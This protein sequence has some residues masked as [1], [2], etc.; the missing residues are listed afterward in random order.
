LR[1]EE[2]GTARDVI[3]LLG[4]LPILGKLF[5]YDVAQKE[6]RHLIVSLRVNV[7]GKQET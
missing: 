7:I 6:K 2:N 1:S 4:Q 3:P 5:R